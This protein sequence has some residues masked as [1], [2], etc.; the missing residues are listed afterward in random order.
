MNVKQLM[1]GI[2]DRSRTSFAVSFLAG[3]F[4]ATSCAA[5]NVIEDV[6]VA[7]GAAGRTTLTFALKD[8]IA[9]P[10][11]V[12]AIATPPRLVLDFANTTSVSKPTTDVSD[13]V[14]RSFNVVQAQG[15]TRVVLNLTRA[16]AYDMK[17]DGRSLTF[18]L[19][20]AAG[21]VAADSALKNTKKFI[22]STRTA[23][24]WR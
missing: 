23:R 15:R 21:T 5:Q 17:A 4:L 9:G 14:L 6:V 10:P 3:I 7:K 12:F 20:D 19:F 18:A 1:R 22:L 8:G 16:Q 24:M 13:S 11:S 2:R